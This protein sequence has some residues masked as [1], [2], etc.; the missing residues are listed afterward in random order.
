MDSRYLFDLDEKIVLRMN[1]PLHPWALA[2]KRR[3]LDQL[4]VFVDTLVNASA[5]AA[6]DFLNSGKLFL[7]LRAKHDSALPAQQLPHRRQP[8]S[9]RGVLAR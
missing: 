3:S 1:P 2:Q 9:G 6:N 4:A 5:V 8:I 7:R